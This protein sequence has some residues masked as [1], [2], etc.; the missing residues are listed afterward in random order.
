MAATVV[1]PGLFC[2]PQFYAA[3]L[4]SLWRAG[5]VQF[6]NHTRDETMADIARRILDEAPQ[7]FALI[8]HSMGGYVAF[9]MLRQAPQR[10]ERV[11]FLDTSA[12]PDAPEQSER[13]RQLIEQAAKGR[14]EDVVDQLY[15]K[16]V[17]P[18]RLDEAAL[19]ETVRQMA[20]DTGAAAFIRQERAI[21][22]RAD[23]RPTLAAI[24]CPTLVLVGEQDELTPPERAEEIAQGVAGAVKVV[25]P[26]CGHMTA[27]ERPEAV[28][29][30]LERWLA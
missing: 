26:D 22:S 4:P 14:Y 25:V 9:E 3:Q 16:F 15:L 12:L 18:A 28:T 6:A 29:A 5:A 1:I 11:A 24:R 8:G 23:S 2:T 30:A 20:R 10:I 17:H 21:I 19:R 13:R 27:M 7:R